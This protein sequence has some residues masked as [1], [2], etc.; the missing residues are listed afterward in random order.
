ML[1]FLAA[2]APAVIGGIMGASKQKAQD[3]AAKA[4]AAE[5]NKLA[6]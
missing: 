2:A 6:K 4:A 3:S 1:G 5:Q